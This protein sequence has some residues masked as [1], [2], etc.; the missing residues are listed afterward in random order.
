MS[1][2]PLGLLKLHSAL[3]DLHTAE[4]WIRDTVSD[5]ESLADDVSKSTEHIV[6]DIVRQNW[7]I[8]IQYQRDAQAQ[9]TREAKEIKALTNGCIVTSQLLGAGVANLATSVA[10]LTAILAIRGV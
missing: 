8:L 6:S 1:N 10:F 7:R 9:M 5:L 2:F 3:A 4:N